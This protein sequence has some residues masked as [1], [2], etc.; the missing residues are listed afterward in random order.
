MRG[1]TPP[2]IPAAEWLEA[3]KKGKAGG[4]C[5][6]HCTYLRQC[7]TKRSRHADE[8]SAK[9]KTTCLKYVFMYLNTIDIIFFSAANPQDGLEKL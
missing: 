9:G 4:S 7:R 3:C 5:Q 6:H 1:Q 8:R 2:T